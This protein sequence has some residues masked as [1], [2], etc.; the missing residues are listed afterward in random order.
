MIA[1]WTIKH[2]KNQVI[3]LVFRKAKKCRL[4]INRIDLFNTYLFNTYLFNT[5]LFDTYLFNTC[6]FQY[7]ILHSVI[8]KLPEI[9][10][11]FQ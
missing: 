3:S 6:F 10:Q 5:H 4:F 11:Y 7:L 1:K 9:V 2:E 8:N